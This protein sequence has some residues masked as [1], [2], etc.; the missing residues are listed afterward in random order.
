MRKNNILKISMA[1]GLICLLMLVSFPIVNAEE[2][3]YPKEDGPY[4]IYLHGKSDG[5]GGEFANLLRILPFWYLKYPKFIQYHILS[6]SW[7]F[8]NGT[9]Q[10]I[11]DPE[12]IYFFSFYGFKGYGP[13]YLIMPY[14]S[15]LV[16][17]I[18]VFGNCDEIRVL[19]Q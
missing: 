5:G 4:S 15:W 14:V 10:E 17:G 8:V 19:I 1:V 7:F 3:I 13:S 11:P 16:G 9:S 18:H 12:E 6:L 2:I